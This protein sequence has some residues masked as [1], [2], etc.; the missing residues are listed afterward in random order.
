LNQYDAVVPL[1]ERDAEVYKK[2]G[3]SLPIRV[4]PTGIQPVPHSTLS[5]QPATRK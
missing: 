3:C 1:T 4:S 2:W 5:G